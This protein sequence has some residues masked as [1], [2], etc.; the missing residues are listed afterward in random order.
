MFNR[1]FVYE[2]FSWPCFENKKLLVAVFRFRDPEYRIRLFPGQSFFDKGKRKAI[3]S[4][5]GFCQA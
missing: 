5:D 1:K 3:F 2:N 4:E